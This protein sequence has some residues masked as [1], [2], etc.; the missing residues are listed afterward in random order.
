MSTF[1]SVSD[2]TLAQI[3]IDGRPIFYRRQGQGRPLLLLHGWGGSSLYW[4]DA[5][6]VYSASRDVIAPDLPGFGDSPP[7]D[8]P[9]HGQRLADLTLAF[10]DALGLEQF[11]LNGH[12]FSAGVSAYM[13]AQSPERVR[14]L[15]LTSFSTFSSE[16]ERS[17]VDQMHK[18]MALWMTL[19]QPW[20]AERRLF[21]RAVASRFFYRT[22]ANDDLLRE[23][24]A[25][26][27]RM[28]KRT[29]IESAASSADPAINVALSKITSPTL[30]IGSRQD[31][32]M[33][34]QGTPAVADLIPGAR[35]IWIERCGHLPMIERP[36]LYHNIV[37]DFLA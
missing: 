34:P 16:F 22:P 21:Y 35:L 31:N 36:R 15:I 3:T 25:D 32:I 4:R 10:T 5:L 24:A 17:M 37:S 19:R 14:R 18:V 26:F 2:D 6:S 8:G 29:A 7:L 13:A 30:V 12:S 33:P 11:D 9:L 20:M 27:L 23:S 28:D 1:G